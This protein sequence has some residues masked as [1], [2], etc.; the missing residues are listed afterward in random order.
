MATNPPGLAPTIVSVDS[1]PADVMART[2]PVFNAGCGDCL[3]Y[4]MQYHLASL[5]RPVD[6]CSQLRRGAAAY[7]AS[8]W[9]RYRDFALDPVTLE[10]YGSRGA[11]VRRISTPGVDADHVVLHALCRRLRVGAYLVVVHPDGSLG[12]P[13]RMCCHTGWP[14]LPFMFQLEAHYQALAGKEG[15]LDGQARARQN[16]SRN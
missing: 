10:A 5:G 1:R 7:V 13:I 8:H 15:E 6:S 12:K 11:C 3:F 2:R 9:A 16:S 14:V 4:S